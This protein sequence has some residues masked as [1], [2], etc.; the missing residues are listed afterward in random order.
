MSVGGDARPPFTLYVVWHPDYA[1]GEIIAERLRGRFSSE[2]YRNL[3]GGSGVRVAFRS[4]AAPD[5]D[6]PHPIRWDDTPIAAVVVLLDQRF[7]RDSSRTR[8]LRQL[9]S[10]ALLRSPAARVFPISMEDGVLD[11]ANLSEQAIRWDRWDERDRKQ[12][13]F[14]DLTHE[15]CRMLR[16]HLVLL[17]NPSEPEPNLLAM[18]RPV[19]VFLSHSTHD[20]DGSRIAAAINDWINGNTALRAFLYVRDIPPGLSFSSVLFEAIQASALLAIRTDSYASRPW[21]RREVIEAK[22]H[23]VP[24]VVVD[25]LRKSEDRSFPY[26]GNVPTVRLDSTGTIEIGRV[27]WQLL[28]EVFKDFLW[29]CR[30]ERL[31]AAHPDTLFVPRSPELLSLVSLGNIQP[32]ASRAIVYPDPCL[33]VEEATLFRDAAHDVELFTLTDWLA[34]RPT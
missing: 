31:R 29:H 19:Q 4:V 24:L 28:E 11:A 26:L 8:Y 23:H 6:V 1:A 21:C 2:R 27:V 12:R 30:V 32:A 34:E 15:F 22:R 18:M 20:E 16:H 7:V 5:K 14:R 33:D 10:E 3:L 17:R 9:S 25:S 13:L